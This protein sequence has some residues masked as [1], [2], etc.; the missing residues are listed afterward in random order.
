MFSRL[1]FI[2]FVVG[3]AVVVVAGNA[4][5]GLQPVARTPDYGRFHALIIGNDDYKNIPKL[6]S[7]GHD[8]K[9][10][11]A[12][13]KEKY[14]FDVTLLL[15]ATRYQIMSA[16]SRLRQ[17]LTETDNLLIYFAG[18]GVLY[19][20]ADAGFWLPVDA[21]PDNDANWIP[22]SDV[23]RYLRTIEARHI[24]VIADTAFAGTLTR[25]TASALA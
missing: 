7:A 9:A 17:K 21:E 18:H 16:F 22:N 8:A 4:S 23:A 24:I 6:Q 3:L 10:I 2:I 11:S 12:V 19:P 13:L 20:A 14:G 1:I 15:D 5:A 25:A